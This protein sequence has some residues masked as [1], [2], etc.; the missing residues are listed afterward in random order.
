MFLLKKY[1][2][3]FIVLCMIYAVVYLSTYY[4]IL[5]F[6]ESTFSMKS[7]RIDTWLRLFFN[8]Y[9]GQ[10]LN[11][12]WIGNAVLFMLLIC[13]KEI[14]HSFSKGLILKLVILTTFIIIAVKGF[15][16]WRYMFTLIPLIVA[17]LSIKSAE[18]IDPDEKTMTQEKYFWF[19]SIL[20]LSILNIIFYETTSGDFILSRYVGLSLLILSTT[21]LYGIIK[22]DAFIVS[23]SCALITIS[24]F[25][26]FSFASNHTYWLQVGINCCSVFALIALF[27]NRYRIT[28]YIYTHLPSWM[29][30]ITLLL[31]LS[32]VLIYFRFYGFST[33]I[34]PN[35][36]NA[37]LIFIFLGLFSK[38]F[39]GFKSE[40]LL[41]PMIL[42]LCIINY[43]I[44]HIG[45]KPVNGFNP[46]HLMG[47]YTYDLKEPFMTKTSYELIAKKIHQI[48]LPGEVVLLNHIPAM[49]YYSEDKYLYYWCQEDHYF[50]EEGTKYLFKNR[51]EKQVLEKLRSLHV[52]Y[53][54]TS[55]YKNQYC[56]VPLQE[57]IEKNTES[58]FSETGFHFYK[59]K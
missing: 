38:Y 34:Y 36:G 43:K 45:K 33:L 55:E 25:L 32:A 29:A 58:I 9:L 30:N 14:T 26:R 48:V 50:N 12:F 47:A 6:T 11:F 53:I 31:L 5:P 52:A 44:N 41:Y 3:P 1:T 40:N 16:G 59:L 23:L 15:F 28:D 10:I 49:Y 17:Y 35:E 7:R 21:L 2:K 54:L 4:E 13:G 20:F 39:L 24:L 18:S 8:G 37:I 57:F 19:L 56:N 51:D 22:K 42:F 46:L 27:K